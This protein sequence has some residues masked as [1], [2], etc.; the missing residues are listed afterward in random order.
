MVS[1]TTII[2]DLIQNLGK[3]VKLTL[4]RNFGKVDN[5]GN[6]L[7]EGI[8]QLLGLIILDFIH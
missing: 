1:F 4:P 2:P 8:H 6:L 3:M 5:I 7:G